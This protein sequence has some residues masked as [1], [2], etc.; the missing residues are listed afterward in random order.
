MS[1]VLFHG[2]IAGLNPGDEITPEHDRHVDGCPICDAT[3]AGI[4]TPFDIPTPEGWVYATEDRQYA[5]HYA[6]LV[7]LGWLYRVQLNG[8]IEPSTE[9]PFP[10][11]RGR[12][13]TVV[14]VLE[15]GVRLTT[16]ER[17]RLFIRWGGTA[18]QFDLMMTQVR[19][20]A[21]GALL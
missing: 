12:T 2:G 17:R 3:R 13:A 14:S 11:W 21:R 20:H 8:D 15:R 1:L 7:N 19:P 5:R 9:D 10:S 6:S 18:S 16:K 4:A